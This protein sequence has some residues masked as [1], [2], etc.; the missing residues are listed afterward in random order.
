M[1]GRP[2]EMALRDSESVGNANRHH[3]PCFAM[4]SRSGLPE[5]IDGRFQVRAKFGEV[6]GYGEDTERAEHL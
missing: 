3:F 6:E 2:L 5:S 4:V 1:I